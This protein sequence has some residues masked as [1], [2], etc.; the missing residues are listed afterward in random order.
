ME[1]KTPAQCPTWESLVQL[2]TAVCS[3]VRCVLQA[4]G[5]VWGNY[6]KK[7]EKF[8]LSNMQWY[9]GKPWGCPSFSQWL[10]CPNKTKKAF[11]RVREHAWLLVPWQWH[12]QRCLVYF[13]SIALARQLAGIK[14]N[15]A[16]GQMTKYPLVSVPFC[17]CVCP[18]LEMELMTSSLSSRHLCRWAEPL[19]PTPWFFFF[20]AGG[21][22]LDLGD[23]RHTCH[24]RPTCSNRWCCLGRTG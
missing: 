24:S 7:R 8:K 1:N 23:A 17:V 16:F 11:P 14:G 12:F 20:S 10:F 22:D 19:A 21:S 13:L 3:S 2:K 9:A 4:C 15:T 5:T 6:I 18:V